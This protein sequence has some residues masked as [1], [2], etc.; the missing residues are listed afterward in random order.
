M[1]KHPQYSRRYGPKEYIDKQEQIHKAFTQKAK[2]MDEFIEKIKESL[3]DEKGHSADHEKSL[4][5]AIDHMLKEKKQM[6]GV[7]NDPETKWKA[8]TQTILDNEEQITNWLYNPKTPTKQ[9][10]H[11]KIAS[12]EPIGKGFIHNKDDNFQSFESTYCAVV[13]V[14]DESTPLGFKLLTAFPGVA[15]LKPEQ[16][17]E[18]LKIS[19]EPNTEIMRQTDAFRKGTSAYKSYLD[20]ISDPKHEFLAVYREHMGTK[21]TDGIYLID[22][23]NHSKETGKS[24]VKYTASIT[25]G[26]SYII[27]N[28]RKTPDDPWQQAPWAALDSIPGTKNRKGY[29]LNTPQ[30]RGQVNHAIQDKSPKQQKFYAD[31]TEVI[32]NLQRY[33]AEIE[34]RK[35]KAKSTDHDKDDKP[36]TPPSRTR[37]LPNIDSKPNDGHDGPSGPSK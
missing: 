20:Y 27:K 36:P 13:L 33:A 5:G 8:V 26:N 29:P 32:E 4:P 11:T 24:L 30:Q 16:Q 1:Y 28:T 6:H 37:D 18:L 25:K 31:V 10:F 22:F 2:T 9:G 35:A 21:P 34:A 15:D 23:R 12:S 17:R 14:K 3:A 19:D 7:F